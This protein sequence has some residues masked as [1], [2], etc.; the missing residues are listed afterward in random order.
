LDEPEKVERDEVTREGGREG[1]RGVSFEVVVGF[2]G[3]WG[4]AREGGRGGGVGGEGYR[5]T[6]VFGAEGR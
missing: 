1:G 2:W 6:L 3:G 5:H 4:C